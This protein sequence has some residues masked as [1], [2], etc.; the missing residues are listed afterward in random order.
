MIRLNPF[1][2]SVFQIWTVAGGF[3][4]IIPLWLNKNPSCIS[5][6]YPLYRWKEKKRIKN[7]NKRLYIYLWRKTIHHREKTLQSKTNTLVS[8]VKKK[9]LLTHPPPPQWVSPWGRTID[10]TEN[11]GYK[12]KIKKKLKTKIQFPP[13]S[14][15]Q[16]KGR[17]TRLA[18]FPPACRVLRS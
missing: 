6:Q 12:K 7:K 3:I 18:P 4:A 10:I 2:Y 11:T 1:I 9:K 14:I 17:R 15:L 16:K 8:A 5:M 13:S